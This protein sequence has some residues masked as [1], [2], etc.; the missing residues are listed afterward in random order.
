MLAP[1]P[2][3]TGECR[4]P[5]VPRSCGGPHTVT[6]P[7][8]QPQP[9]STPRPSQP[10]ARRP[11]KKDAMQLSGQDGTDGKRQDEQL[12]MMGG[13]Q[14]PTTP[15]AT[16]ETSTS[17]SQKSMAL[18]GHRGA[19]DTPLSGGTG[20]CPQLGRVGRGSGLWAGLWG[21]HW[22][23][24][25]PVPVVE[26]EGAGATCGVVLGSVGQQPVCF[27]VGAGPCWWVSVA[28]PAPRPQAPPPRCC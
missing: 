21:Q 27:R 5:T 2:E 13:S 1:G 7:R 17:R 12:S 22:L 28:D 24:G 18:S 23:L 3:R 14:M 25:Q 11:N 8:F 4:Y 15:T 9:P 16:P 19:E 10:S 20:L 26:L 6:P